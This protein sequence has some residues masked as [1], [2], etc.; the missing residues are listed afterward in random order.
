MRKKPAY[1]CDVCSSKA[2]TSRL[3]IQLSSYNLQTKQVRHLASEVLDADLCDEHAEKTAESLLELMKLVR[4]DP[5]AKA[6]D[7][8]AR[9]APQAA[10][11]S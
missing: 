11:E 8:H 1:L 10:E 7:H 5:K 4:A 6:Q 9:M 3:K 2:A